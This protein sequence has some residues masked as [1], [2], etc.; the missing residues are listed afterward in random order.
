MASLGHNELNKLHVLSWQTVNAF[1]RKLFWLL[2]PELL[3]WTHKQFATPHDTLISL[4]FFVSYLPVFITAGVSS[5]KTGGVRGDGPKEDSHDIFEE[6][7]EKD[8]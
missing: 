6:F 3:S 4:N 5:L 1:I 7:R 8:G 2:F